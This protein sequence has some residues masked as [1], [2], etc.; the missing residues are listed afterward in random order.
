MAYSVTVVGTQGLFG[1][2][3]T[4][5]VDSTQ[6]SPTDVLAYLTTNSAKSAT[7]TGG[8]FGNGD[9]TNATVTGTTSTFG[10][11]SIGGTLDLNNGDVAVFTESLTGGFFLTDNLVV[12]NGA[13]TVFAGNGLGGAFDIIDLFAGNLS[14]LPSVSGASSAAAAK[15]AAVT[16]TVSGAQSS[17]IFNTFFLTSSGASSVSAVPS[18]FG[19]NLLSSSVKGSS[20]VVSL[21]GGTTLTTHGVNPSALASSIAGAG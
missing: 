2:G 12:T 20:G 9:I 1:L 14:F 17:S 18:I 10:A 7:V 19:S 21:P 13:D 8:P 11:G 4:V 5:T 3:G 16:S 6:A 15:T